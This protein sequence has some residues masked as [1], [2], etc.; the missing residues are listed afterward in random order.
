[1][2]DFIL[3][4]KISRMTLKS[5]ARI[6]NFRNAKTTVNKVRNG[7]SFVGLQIHTNWRKMKPKS[8]RKMKARIRY[9]EKEYAAGLIDLES[10]NSTMQSYY[11]LMDHCNSYGLRCW[12]EKNITFKR[13]EGET[14]T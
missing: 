9:I 3:Q 12:I 8:L 13:S 10:V 1:M 5:Y 2:A 14:S 6:A 4:Q 7:I 11:G